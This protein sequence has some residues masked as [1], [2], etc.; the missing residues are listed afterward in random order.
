MSIPFVD[1]LID[2]AYPLVIHLANALAPVGGAAAAI[3]LATAALR[4]LLLPLT[5]AAVRGERSRAALAPKVRELQQRYGR[6]RARLGTELTEL[7]RAEG[8]SPLAG[9]LPALVQA[10]FF[11]ITYRVFSAARIAGQPNVLLTHQLFGVELSTRLIGGGHPFAFVPFV[12]VLVGLGMLADRRARRVA[13]AN[14]TGAPS[15]IMRVLPYLTGASLL[16]MPLAA[17]LYLVTTVSWTAVENALLRRGLPA[18][19]A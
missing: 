14:G 12:A 13:A 19:G 17:A 18:R 10:P 5:M 9:C 6:D 7:Y 16:V 4:A 15:G 1:G 11:M 3:V 2:A 8:V